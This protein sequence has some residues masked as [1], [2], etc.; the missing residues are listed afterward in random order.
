MPFL[1]AQHIATLTPNGVLSKDVQLQLAQ[2]ATQAKE[3]SYSPYSKFRVGA[4]LLAP[5]GE[6]VI[7]LYLP[8]FQYI[9][10]C[11]VENASYGGTICAERTAFVK[12][13]SEGH[14]KFLA[15]AVIT[16]KEAAISPCGFCRQF[17]V[18]FGKHIQVYQFSASFDKVEIKS[19]KELLPDSF[20]PEDLDK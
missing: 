2:F 13:V 4:A 14:K 18:E 15:I 8:L 20:G 6:Q 5:T 7:E 10:G 9:V 11:N 3:M 12:A 19:L 17:M 16:D 1:S